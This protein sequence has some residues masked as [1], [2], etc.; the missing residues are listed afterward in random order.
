MI[1]RPQSFLGG[2]RGGGFVSAFNHSSSPVENAVLQVC[3]KGKCRL[4]SHQHTFPGD[5]GA[6]WQKHT[7]VTAA[8]AL[9]KA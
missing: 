2:E 3:G 7:P 9:S 6:D 4:V 1:E 5:W 8:T